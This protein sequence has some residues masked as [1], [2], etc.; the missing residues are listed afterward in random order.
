MRFGVEVKA[1]RDELV[2]QLEQAAIGWEHND[3]PTLAGEAQRAVDLLKGGAWSAR[4][5]HV[6]YVVTD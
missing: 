1:A 5:G 4:V 6:V 3:K 2:T